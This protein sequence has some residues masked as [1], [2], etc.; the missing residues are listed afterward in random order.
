MHAQANIRWASRD[1]SS[2]ITAITEFIERNMNLV[3]GV[4][5]GSAFVQVRTI[6]WLPLID[7][8]Q[9]FTARL[10]LLAMFLA[11]SLQVNI[12]VT[13]SWY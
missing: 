10:Q 4:C 9:C 2:L 3:A 12:V 8:H 1:N 5:L 11:R 7:D 13:T 6:V